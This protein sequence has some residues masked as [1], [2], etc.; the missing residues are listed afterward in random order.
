MKK[1]PQWFAALLLCLV[2]AAAFVHAAPA[3]ATSPKKPV[4]V[5][6]YFLP[7]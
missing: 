3:P 6:Y 5:T 2:W 7:G 4:E 1:L